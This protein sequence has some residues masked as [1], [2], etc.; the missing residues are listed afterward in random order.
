MISLLPA[1]LVLA[2]H[3]PCATAAP[4][5]STGFNVSEGYNTN[6]DL[7]GQKGWRAVGSGGNG[8]LTSAFPGQG[9]QAYV[10]YTAP[11]AGN[12]YLFVYQPINKRLP[13][14]QFSVSMSVVDS[15]TSARD[16]FHWSVYNQE[17]D[18]LFGLDFDNYDLGVYYY[19]DGTNARAPSGLWFTNNTIYPLTVKMDFSRNRWSATFDGALLATNQP[20]TT[21]GLPLNLGDIDAGWAVFDSEAPGN[22]YMLFDNYQITASAPPPQLK[23]LG[24]VGGA[25]VLRLTGSPDLGF[26]IEGSTNLT[27]W[28]A[29]KTNIATGGSFD[30]LDAGAAGLP[31]RFYRARWVP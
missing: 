29:L 15:T 25:P 9:Q 30:Y 20:I 17:G 16:D 13:E 6:L 5:Y 14:V 18:F 23:L 27:G 12:S 8:L 24:F 3:A 11:A 21:T 28:T 10:G 31:R 26:A 19:L 4:V 1:L 7:V 2:A 22:N